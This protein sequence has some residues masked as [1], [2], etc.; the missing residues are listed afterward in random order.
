VTPRARAHSS[1][2]AAT[3]PSATSARD[4]PGAAAAAARAACGTGA[5]APGHAASAAGDMYTWIG[6]PPQLL[7]IMPMGIPRAATASAPKP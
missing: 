2:A 4:A 7:A 6:T 3:T 5:C 1:S